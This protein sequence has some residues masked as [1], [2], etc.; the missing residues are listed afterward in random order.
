MLAGIT[1]TRVAP[2]EAQVAG[3]PLRLEIH[4]DRD[5]F[6]QDEPMYCLLRLTNVSDK[7]V[8]VSPFELWSNQLDFRFYREPSGE[9]VPHAGSSCLKL[10]GTGLET[11]LDRESPS[12]TCRHWH[13]MECVVTTNPG[14]TIEHCY[15]A[16]TGSRLDTNPT[17][18]G[19]CLT[20][21]S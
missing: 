8:Y 19:R 6:Y 12:I 18:E 3:G 20:K 13:T 4:L 16:S 5:T 1:V 14:P 15:P 9:M 21:R 7:T 17:Y 11:P 2:V 10:T